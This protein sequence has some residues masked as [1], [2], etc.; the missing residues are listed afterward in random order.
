MNRASIAVS[1][2]VLAIIGVACN[3]T[4]VSPSPPDARRPLLLLTERLET[5]HFRFYYSPGDRIDVERSEAY[6]RWATAY[7]GVWTF[8]RIEYYK[9]RQVEDMVLCRYLAGIRVPA[10]RRHWHV[11]CLPEPHLHV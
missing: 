2:F 8:A 9:F 4:P 3:L 7:L 11:Q 1:I 5:E 6:H 10:G